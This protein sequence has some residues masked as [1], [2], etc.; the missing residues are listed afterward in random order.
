MGWG[1]FVTVAACCVSPVFS[2]ATGA[3]SPAPGEMPHMPALSCWLVKP[4]FSPPAVTQAW[5]MEAEPGLQPAGSQG[6][7]FL[8]PI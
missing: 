6:R 5:S 2:N 3:V 1:G 7:Q 8:S 4:G